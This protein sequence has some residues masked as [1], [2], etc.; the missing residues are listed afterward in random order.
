MN[1]CKHEQ[2][3][4]EIVKELSDKGISLNKS[5]ALNNEYEQIVKELIKELNDRNISLNEYIKKKIN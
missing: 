3:I 5:N 1:Y 4:Q 2:K